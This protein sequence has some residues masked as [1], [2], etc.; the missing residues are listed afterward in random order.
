MELNR[1]SRNVLETGP[2]GNV[3]RVSAYGKTRLLPVV[4]R[5][6]RSLDVAYFDFVFEMPILELLVGTVAA[7]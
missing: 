3:S 4:Q 7:L 6:G 2:Q 1:P 5:F